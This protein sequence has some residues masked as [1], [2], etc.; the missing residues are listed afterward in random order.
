VVEELD[1]KQEQLIRLVYDKI[2]FYYR[3][4]HGTRPCYRYPLS[5]SRLMRL[6]RRSGHAVATALR[7][8]ANTVPEGTDTLPL[9]Y[10]DRQQARKNKSHRPYRIFLR[11]KDDGLHIVYVWGIPLLDWLSRWSLPARFLMVLAAS[12]LSINRP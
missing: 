1:A 9:V 2:V 4:L 3:E 7:Y 11:R 12:F 6:C 5:L 8:L 10:Y